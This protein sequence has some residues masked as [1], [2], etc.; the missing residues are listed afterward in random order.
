MSGAQTDRV[1][2][3]VNESPEGVRR[4]SLRITATDAE[5]AAVEPGVLNSHFEITDGGVGD[6]RVVA[7]AVD[8][9]GEARHITDSIRIVAVRFDAQI[10]L[11]SIDLAIEAIVDHTDDAVDNSAVQFRAAE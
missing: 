10:P 9:T 3:L 4:F 11:E 6:R 1:E 2:V 7:R 5:I 8:F